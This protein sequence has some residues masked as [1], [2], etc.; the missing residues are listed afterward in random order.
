M[1]EKYLYKDKVLQRKDVEEAAKQSGMDID[2]YSTKAGLKRVNDNYNFNG[3]TVPAEE[4]FEAAK[5]SQ[6]GFDDYIQ[7]AKITPIEDVKKKVARVDFDGSS[8][9]AGNVLSQSGGVGGTE[10][11]TVEMYYTPSGELVETDPV[12]LSKSLSN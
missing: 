9:E 12:S 4:I 11:P 3:K 1:P 8:L 2:T 7:K 5:Q 10:I 6:M